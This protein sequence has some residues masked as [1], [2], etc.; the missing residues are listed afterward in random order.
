[1][2]KGPVARAAGSLGQGPCRILSAGAR[3]ALSILTE[4]QCTKYT[5][6]T[7]HT[8]ER[9]ADAPMR[10]RCC[11]AAAR[12]GIARHSVSCH[13]LCGGQSHAPVSGPPRLL[14]RLLA[15]GPLTATGALVSGPCPRLSRLW[16]VAAAHLAVHLAA[17][18]HRACR[19]ACAAPH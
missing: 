13:A 10:R 7:A 6:C 3:C 19:V 2:A 18:P 5:E 14:P 17:P 12:P 1:M 15:R 4:S 11:A 8:V 9:A 16:L